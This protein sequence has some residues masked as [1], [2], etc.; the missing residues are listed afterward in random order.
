MPVRGVSLLDDLDLQQLAAYLHLT[1]DQVQ[2]MVERN[3]IPGRRVGGEWRFSEGEIHHWLEERIGIADPSQLDQVE[4]VLQRAARHERWPRIA[5]LLPQA[6]IAIPLPAKTRGSVIREMCQLAAQSGMLWDPVSMAQAV[7]ER[8]SL[9][10]TA[11]ESGVALLHPR[12]PQTSILADSVLALGI[13]AAPIPFSDAGQMTDIFFL[14]CSYDDRSHLR[15]LA[16]LSRIIARN[17]VVDRIRSAASPREVI[18]LLGEVE[19]EIYGPP[20][21]TEE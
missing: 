5:E 20:P 11:L 2:K 7:Q 10:P 9:H 6:S 21:V 17:E 14:I 12:R 3:R 4:A 16:R 8:E 19:E 13:C 18:E 15:I 1:P